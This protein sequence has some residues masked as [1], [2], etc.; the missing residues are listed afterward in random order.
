MRD[1]R[2]AEYISPE[3]QWKETII[4]QDFLP[5]EAEEIL[6]TSIE[7]DLE[8]DSRY[9]CFHPKGK[10]MIKS[11][12]SRCVEIRE[13]E[14]QAHA[15][16]SSPN[17]KRWW[18]EIWFLQIPPRIKVFWWQLAWDIIPVEKNLACRHVPIQPC[19]LLCG[20][21]EANSIHAIFICPVTRKVWGDM[22]VNIPKPGNNNVCMMD[23]LSRLVLLNPSF[24]KE[25][26]MVV[27]WAV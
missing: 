17:Y 21:A 26:I 7:R 19:C 3:A 23:F 14:S 9:W 2:V 8:R 15:S 22:G 5:F 4:K 27:V 10:Y 13:A 6:S 16:S 20:H 24:Q 11:G 12:Y 1:Q 18:R 25:T